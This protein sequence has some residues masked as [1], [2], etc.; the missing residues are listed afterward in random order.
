M[1][2]IKRNAAGELEIWQ[3]PNELPSDRYEHVLI[4]IYISKV[5]AYESKIEDTIVRRWNLLIANRM[6]EVEELDKRTGEIEHYLKAK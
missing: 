6:R 3:D 2:Y 1:F 5:T 4:G